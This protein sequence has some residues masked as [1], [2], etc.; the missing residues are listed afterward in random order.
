M[1]PLSRM[2]PWSLAFPW[3][4]DY[5]WTAWSR[6]I[7]LKANS[8]FVAPTNCSFHHNQPKSRNFKW[9]VHGM[10]WKSL[11]SLSVPIKIKNF[12]WRTSWNI[13][14]TKANLCHQKVLDSPICEACGLEVETSRHLFWHCEKIREIW[15]FSGLPLNFN[16]VHFP[17]FIDLL[18]YLKFVQH[19]GNDILELF[20]TIAWSI[21]FNW[22]QVWQR[23]TR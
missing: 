23:K 10:F 7:P 22:N 15:M 6:L 2:S 14:P 17:E 9:T 21:W 16:G 1:F 5:Q 8:R 19:V 4:L 11:W 20:I 12:A 13:L 3:A 18:W